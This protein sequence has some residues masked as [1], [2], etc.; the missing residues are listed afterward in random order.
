[1][2]QHGEA[3]SADLSFLLDA[4]NFADAAQTHSKSGVLAVGEGYAQ[5]NLGSYR[6]ALLA[7]NKHSA[8]GQVSRNASA[9]LRDPL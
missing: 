1:M 8:C 3:A 4:Q 2:H 7:A 6:R 5:L 9:V